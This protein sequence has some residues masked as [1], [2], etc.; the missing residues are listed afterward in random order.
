[1]CGGRRPGLTLTPTPPDRADLPPQ[2]AAPR[3]RAP[4]ALIQHHAADPK[5]GQEAD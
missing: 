2:A 5:L 3:A 1:M 4:L